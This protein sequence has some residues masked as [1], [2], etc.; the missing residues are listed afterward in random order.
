M[1]ES[2]LEILFIDPSGMERISEGMVLHPDQLKWANKI[3]KES[4][5]EVYIFNTPSNMLS[6]KSFLSLYKLLRPRGKVLGGNKG[7]APTKGVGPR[8]VD[9]DGLVEVATIG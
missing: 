6:A 1:T 4:F 5:D 9:P 2:K 7:E 8:G 3:Q